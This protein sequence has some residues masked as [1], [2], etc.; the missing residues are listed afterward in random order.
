MKDATIRE[1]LL[2]HDTQCRYNL[3]RLIETDA[4]WEEIT[5]AVLVRF[6]RRFGVD[7]VKTAVEY[8]A[9]ERVLPDDPYPYLEAMCARLERTMR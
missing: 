7:V 4:R 5:P 1:A 6:G 2:A 3:R 8:A 9:E